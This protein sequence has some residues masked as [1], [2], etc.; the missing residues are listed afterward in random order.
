MQRRVRRMFGF[1]LLAFL[2]LIGWQSY[3]H[4]YAS[5]WLLTTPGNRRLVQAER[6]IPR[7]VIYDTR[8]RK[9][10][11]SEE[12]KRHYADPTV[13]APVLGYLDV[14][15][16]RTGVEGLWDP[17]LSGLSRHFTA[18][19]LRRIIAGEKPRGHDL[20]LTLDLRLQQ[21]AQQ[22]LGAQRGAIV[23]LD[24]AT[25]AIRALAS[26]PT[27]NPLTIGAD[28]PDII[29]ARNG[30]LRNRAL[31]DHYP[32]GSTMKVVTAAAALINDIGADTTFTCPGRSRIYNVTVTDYRG[33]VH[34]PLDMDAALTQSC[35]NY[36]ARLAVRAGAGEFSR[37]AGAFGFGAPW[38]RKLEDH[39]L[40]PVPADRGMPALATSTLAP[41]PNAPISDGELAHMG[42]G[43]STVVATPL[44]MAM[45]TAAVANDG[46]SMAPFLVAQV[47]KGGTPQ[48]LK[49]YRS[50]PIGFPLDRDSA[51]ALQ[52]MMRHV[53]TRG[54]GW[55]ANVRGL[56]VY[57]KTG[58]AQQE[59]G[60][61]H[62]WFIGFARSERTSEQLAFAVLIERGGTGGRAAVP[63]AKQM[64][65][66]WA[67]AGDN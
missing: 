19:E 65:E 28:Y 45:V 12:G 29:R 43:Q 49:R 39:R 14:Q 37:T 46:Q 35:N 53:V 22:A 2:V 67:R 52:T 4:L 62:A 50:L 23:A 10:A 27:F 64:L 42:F 48:V 8:G 5:N 20:V 41:D 36:F 33:T 13:T 15:Y 40:L 38:W 26:S 60:A 55:G 11:W 59:G 34:G 30:A 31:Q 6:G 21:A 51:R 54:T 44:Q 17:E 56:T 58:T 3:W 1:F 16:G 9:L 47:R 32:P 18:S 61:D 24:P 25:G 63:V 7:G 66:A 57:G